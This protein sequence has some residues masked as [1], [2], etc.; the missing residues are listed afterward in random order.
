MLSGSK[1]SSSK[2]ADKLHPSNH[3][4]HA[5]LR[6][7]YVI[8]PEPAAARTSRASVLGSGTM[9]IVKWAAGSGLSLKSV[10]STS[11]MRGVVV[12]ERRSYIPKGVPG[13]S[14]NIISVTWY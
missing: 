8:K 4:N 1:I 7:R 5:D 2:R 6:R 10:S 9:L 13:P 11:E 14:V 12:V 3:V